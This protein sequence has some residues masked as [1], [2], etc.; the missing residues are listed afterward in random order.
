MEF[1]S[2]MMQPKVVHEHCDITEHIKKETMDFKPMVKRKSDRKTKQSVTDNFNPWDVPNLE[3]FLV[4]SCPECDT[5]FKH[6]TRDSFISHA[7]DE[8]PKSRP[9]M[10]MFNLK[11]EEYLSNGFE[12][13]NNGNERFD[14]DVFQFGG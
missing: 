13:I 2:S 11:Q 6:D 8:H 4:Y 3:Q 14:V 10:F 9:F 12:N 5:N 7:N 1:D